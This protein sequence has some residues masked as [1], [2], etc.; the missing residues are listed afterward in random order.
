MVLLSVP[1]D[2]HRLSWQL[3][4]VKHCSH[5]IFLPPFSQNRSNL[6]SQGSHSSPASS[7]QWRSAG[8]VRGRGRQFNIFLFHSHP[9]K[10]LTPS[11]H[12]LN[13]CFN[14]GIISG[15]WKK[16]LLPPRRVEQW[17]WNWNVN[18]KQGD[19]R[20]RSGEEPWT[21]GHQGRVCRGLHAVVGGMVLS[22]RAGV[23]GRWVLRAER[24]G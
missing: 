7:L 4:V 10:Q 23:H 19:H 15:L 9:C 6:Q 2:L 14:R 16:R 17:A 20:V 21:V 3:S 22:G 1:L 12:K 24:R 18:G 11:G 8:A 13:Y 5:W